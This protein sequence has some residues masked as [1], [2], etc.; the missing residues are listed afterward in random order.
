MTDRADVSRLLGDH[1]RTFALTLRIL[2]HTLREPLGIAYLLARASDTIADAP[3]ISRE[4]RLD[5]LGKLDAD[6]AADKPQDWRPDVDPGELPPD[7]RNLLA[8]LPAML[9]ACGNLPDK[10]QILRLWRTILQGQLFDLRRFGPAASPL[11]REE[12]EFYCGLVAGS[13]GSAWT[14]LIARHAPGVPVRPA[15]EMIPLGIA[16]GKGL[17]L[18]NILRDREEDRALGRCYVREED[19]PELLDRAEEWLRSAERYLAGLRPGRVL[20]ATSLPLGLAVP[21]LAL[22]KEHPEQSRVKLPRWRVRRIL[23][24][25]AAS[26][27]LPRPVDPAS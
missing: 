7:G 26:L 19:L 5:L 12:L 14:R 23:M 16:Y 1:A 3:E 9:G 8:C 6:L 17:Q 20:M 13:V 27:W 25:S 24:R 2:P 18:V 15:E 11:S 21:T 4:R 10:D 22:I